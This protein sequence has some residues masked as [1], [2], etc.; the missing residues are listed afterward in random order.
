MRDSLLW[1][2]E[3][4]TEFWAL[5]LAARAGQLSSSQALDILALAAAAAQSRP[6]RTCSTV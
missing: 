3:G 5:A 2:Y 6:G 4:Q 1:V